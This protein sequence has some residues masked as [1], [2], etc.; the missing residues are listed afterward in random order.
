MTSIMTVPSAISRLALLN[1]HIEQKPQSETVPGFPFLTN[2]GSSPYDKDFHTR[3]FTEA[4]KNAP[5]NTSLKY[6]ISYVDPVQV[7]LQQIRNL[8]GNTH[9][10]SEIHTDK[11]ASPW[12]LLAEHFLHSTDTVVC[13]DIDAEIMEN[14]F[15]S[16]PAV[17][18]S[19]FGATSSDL[20]I[21][22]HVREDTE[23]VVLKHIN[24]ASGIRTDVKDVI[25]K[26]KRQ[27]PEAKVVVDAT[28]SLDNIAV[29][30]WDADALVTKR[31]QESVLFIAKNQGIAADHPK[32]G[33]AE[34][35]TTTAYAQLTG[36]V[37]SLL[38]QFAEP[39]P[40]IA[41][42][43][44]GVCSFYLDQAYSTEV[45]A[46]LGQIAKPAYISIDSDENYY[47]IDF[48]EGQQVG[49]DELQ[50]SLDGVVDD[51][52][53]ALTSCKLVAN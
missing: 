10:Q 42:R 25:A 52:A 41:S 43:A 45:R 47:T 21:E 7:E 8:I 13:I 34:D 37:Y 35:S 15:L 53:A 6:A 20:N 46:R 9:R 3:Y 36:N 31:K 5:A 11:D 27:S 44:S 1:T 2:R 51:V 32:S 19:K 18:S 12:D 38:E 4:R 29:D 33:V 22:K 39:I 23:V 50:K 48:I 17:I 16:L 40:P 28:G 14:L 49:L 24:R 30:Q 26:I